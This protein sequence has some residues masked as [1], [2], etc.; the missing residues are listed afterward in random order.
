MIDQ[1]FKNCLC[2]CEGKTIFVLSNFTARIPKTPAWN[3]IGVVMM[4]K[5]LHSSNIY[6]M[7]TKTNRLSNN[8]LLVVIHWPI[9]KKKISKSTIA[10]Y[11][12][13]N[14]T[15]MLSM[16]NIHK[17]IH[18]TELFKRFQARTPTYFRVS[19]TVPYLLVNRSIW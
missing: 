17:T 16:H 4:S 15:T 14:I 5:L 19:I 8:T 2:V 18:I 3:I 9:K 13:D 1:E 12:D 7:S 6:S 11:T 10:T